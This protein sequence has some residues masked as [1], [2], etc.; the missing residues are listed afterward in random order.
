MA[1]G[2]PVLGCGEW[3]KH[4]VLGV[5]PGL[6]HGLVQHESLWLHGQLE[7]FH[8]VLGLGIGGEPRSSP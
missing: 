3:W 8:T 1:A 6:G 2:P 5:G 7:G 4:L